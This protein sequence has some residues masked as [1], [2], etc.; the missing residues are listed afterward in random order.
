MKAIT[1][2]IFITIDCRGNHNKN[3]CTCVYHLLLILRAVTNALP[4][5]ENDLLYVD[6]PQIHMIAH[7]HV[8][9]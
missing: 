4:M 1:S 5:L 6:R 9:V 7:H 2:Y 3:T 8:S